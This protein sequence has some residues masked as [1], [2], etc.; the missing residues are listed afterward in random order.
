MTPNFTNQLNLKTVYLTVL[1]LYILREQF[2]EE[3]D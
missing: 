2:E 3:K 1:C